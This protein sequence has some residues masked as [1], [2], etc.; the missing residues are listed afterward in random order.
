MTLLPHKESQWRV[1]HL[2]PWVD[3]GACRV[4]GKVPHLL[5]WSCSRRQLAAQEEQ[6]A[7]Q[8]SGV[9]CQTVQ[10][11]GVGPPG[12]GHCCCK[13]IAQALDTAEEGSGA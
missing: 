4:A 10:G 2:L 1:Q 5:H 11:R 13:V 12:V 3:L 7:C 6:N 8:R 9:G